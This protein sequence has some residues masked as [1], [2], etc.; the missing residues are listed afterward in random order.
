MENQLKFKLQATN[1]GTY[2]VHRG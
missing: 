2:P 1:Q